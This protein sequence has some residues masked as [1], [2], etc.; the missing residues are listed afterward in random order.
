MKVIIGGGGAGGASGAEQIRLLDETDES[1]DLTLIEML[2]HLLALGVRPANR[3]NPIATD[4]IAFAHGRGEDPRRSRLRRGGHAEVF[5]SI[6]EAGLV[7]IGCL[8]FV[9][10]G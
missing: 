8:G 9:V 4:V 6:G 3:L 5:I 10:C 7:P 2:H 1:F